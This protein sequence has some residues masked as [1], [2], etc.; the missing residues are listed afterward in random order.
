MISIIRKIIG[1]ITPNHA[2]FGIKWSD[3]W[4]KVHHGN[5]YRCVNENDNGVQIKE[6]RDQVY[7][8]VETGEIAIIERKGSRTE[9]FERNN[10]REWPNYVDRAIRNGHTWHDS[11]LD[12]VPT[13]WGEPINRSASSLWKRV[14]DIDPPRSVR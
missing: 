10:R 1:A 3:D 13:F 6:T 7:R 11:D 14:H 12:G 5:V 2:D 8:H 9:W 4:G